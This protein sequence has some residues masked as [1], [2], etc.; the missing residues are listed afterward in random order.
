MIE[1]EVV[2]KNSKESL[3][4]ELVRMDLEGWRVVG[5]STDMFSDGRIYQALLT[6]RTEGQ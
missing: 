3:Q 1:Y 4:D 2:S 6:R 5:F